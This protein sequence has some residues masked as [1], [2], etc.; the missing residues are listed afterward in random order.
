MR[1]VADT[2]PRVRRSV[3]Q[4]QW[5]AQF[6]VASELCKRGYEVALTMGNHP[7]T[8]IMVKSPEGIRFDVDVKGLHKKNFWPVRV[9]APHQNLFYIFAFV[10]ADK[11][12]QFFIMPQDM[13]NEGIQIEID[14]TRASK[15]ARGLPHI[16]SQ[17]FPC[18]SWK[19]AEAHMNAWRVLP[20]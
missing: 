18:V 14:K 8:D 9:K 11:D 7:T 15:A 16:E 2:I 19:F 12:N 6:A 3:H 20:A 5:A 1:I 13:V 17:D 4:T 10:P